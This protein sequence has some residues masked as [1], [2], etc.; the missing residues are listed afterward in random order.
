VWK[1]INRLVLNGRGAV[2]FFWQNGNVASGAGAGTVSLGGR[3]SE[4][5]K[6]CGGA[7]P[8]SGGAPTAARPVRHLTRRRDDDDHLARPGE[9]EHGGGKATTSARPVDVCV[10]GA[11]GWRV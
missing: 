3:G 4:R 11:G 10:P 6:G 7:V 9:N 8:A 2:R 1:V 5:V